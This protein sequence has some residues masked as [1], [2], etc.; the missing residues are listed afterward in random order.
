MT[1][2]DRFCACLPWDIRR[3]GRAWSKEAHGRMRLTPEKFEM[4]D[5]CLF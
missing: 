2:G 5:G 1:R 4:I 3:E